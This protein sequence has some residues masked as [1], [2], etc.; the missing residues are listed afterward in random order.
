[1]NR[2]SQPVLTLFAIGLL[3]PGNVMLSVLV[4]L[5][6]ESDHRGENADGLLS[7]HHLA[8]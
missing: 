2:T 8:P 1:M 3:R 6:R 5:P 4:L 7:L